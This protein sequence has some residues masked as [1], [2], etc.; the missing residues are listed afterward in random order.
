MTTLTILNP[1]TGFMRDNT[2]V[3][4]NLSRNMGGLEGR[5]WIVTAGVAAHDTRR[6]PRFRALLGNTP[7]ITRTQP[8][9][10]DP[11]TNSGSK[12]NLPL[13]QQL[14]PALQKGYELGLVQ[15]G[16]VGSFGL[17]HN[18]IRAVWWVQERM[19]EALLNRDPVPERVNLVG[20]SRGAVTCF[21]IAE[22]LHWYGHKTPGMSRDEHALAVRLRMLRVNIFAMDPVPGALYA[23]Q[24][25]YYEHVIAPPNVRN[26]W[27]VYAE[28]EARGGMKPLI[29]STFDPESR[30]V[31]MRMPGPHDQSVA[32]DEGSAYKSGLTSVFVIVQSLCHSF[33]LK[34]WTRIAR[35]A[36]K[37]EKEL[38]EE[39][40][41]I[42]QRSG[43]YAKFSDP[44]KVASVGGR[45]LAGMHGA[46]APGVA[47]RSVAAG[48]LP[49]NRL[50]A[51]GEDKVL[52]GELLSGKRLEYVNDH[53][54]QLFSRLV[55]DFAFSGGIKPSEARAVESFVTKHQPSGGL[56]GTIR[57][58][59][60]VGDIRRQAEQVKRL[61]LEFPQTY[62]GLVAQGIIRA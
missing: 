11:I 3:V 12:A 10:L 41:K 29:H 40:G 48:T 38:L 61:K 28:H 5:D 49:P 17:E 30:V 42:Q 6:F 55:P 7:D 8:G 25:H 33:L 26:C 18:V 51:R 39:Y 34:N 15:K 52:G 36:I 35:P 62:L 1:G 47:V 27:V 37:S 4:G 59:G 44:G 45:A 20:W 46:S 19:R 32:G 31:R 54:F 21:R 22:E 56:L 14:F 9:M 2:D 16:G 13:N 57:N 24:M 53:H 23:G 58:M 43:D 50:A 60:V